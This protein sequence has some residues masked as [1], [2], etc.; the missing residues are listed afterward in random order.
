M[1]NYQLESNFKLLRD[2]VSI[3]TLVELDVKLDVDL[4]V[5]LDVVPDVELDMELDVDS[6]ELELIRK[7]WCTLINEQFELR[8]NKCYGGLTVLMVC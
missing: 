3:H 1:E 8:Q 6:V 7:T 2:Q 5:E 4:D